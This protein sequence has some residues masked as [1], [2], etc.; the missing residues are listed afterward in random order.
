[1]QVLEAKV[2]NLVETM[3][4]KIDSKMTQREEALVKRVTAVVESKLQNSI[5]QKQKDV[6]QQPQQVSPGT[7]SRNMEEMLSEMKDRESRKPNLILHR[8]DESRSNQKSESVK[9]DTAMFVSLCKETLKIEVAE[10]EVVEVTRLGKKQTGQD[11]RPRPLRVKLN[12]ESIKPRIFKNVHKIANSQFSRV[13]IT[14]D[15]TPMQK[16]QEKKMIEEVTKKNTDEGGSPKIFKV[17]GPPWARKIVAKRQLKLRD[18]SAEQDNPT[19]PAATIVEKPS[20]SASAPDP[21]KPQPRENSAE[22]G[23]QPSK[24]EAESG[25]GG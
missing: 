9:H 12:K 25:G 17:T 13:S 10:E 16:E 5:V 18:V 4:E 8:L 2:D 6:K 14:H 1:M 15:L 21:P 3:D 23:H 20:T 11:Q 22:D 7:K 24:E 19:P